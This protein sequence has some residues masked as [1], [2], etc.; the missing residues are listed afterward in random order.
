MSE[1]SRKNSRFSGKKGLNLV[2]VDLLRVGFDMGEIGVV[3]EIQRHAGRQ[4]VLGVQADLR[5]VCR[6]RA[7]GAH[8]DGDVPGSSKGTIP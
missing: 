4:P 7:A 2:R 6:G 5:A 1:F 8:V 3:G